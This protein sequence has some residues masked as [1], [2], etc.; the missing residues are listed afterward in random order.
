MDDLDFADFNL[1]EEEEKVVAGEPADPAEV[2]PSARPSERPSERPAP[3]SSRWAPLRRRLP[4]RHRA[5]SAARHP[6]QHPPRNRPHLAFS[7]IYTRFKSFVRRKI[8]KRGIKHSTADELQQDVF[9]VL[10]KLIQRDGL[11]EKM[12]ARLTTIPEYVVR[13]HLRWRGRRPRF[14]DG[15]ELD[16]LPAP[17]PDAE[18]QVRVAQ[19][20]RLL[21]AAIDKLQPDDATLIRSID[22]GGMTQK[23]VANEQGRLL[24]TVKSHHQRAQARLGEVMRRLYSADFLETAGERGLSHHALALRMKQEN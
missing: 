15:A 6:S 3:V 8:E 1:W 24:A 2:A 23:Q 7:A 14:V 5:P 12:A 17:E 18:H 9:V 19:Q 20:R 4:H 16:K 10:D 21:D 13:N 22:L 11:P